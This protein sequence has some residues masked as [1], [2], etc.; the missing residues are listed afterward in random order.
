ME[1]YK[2]HSRKSGIVLM[3]SEKSFLLSDLFSPH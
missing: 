2:L 3:C 1:Y